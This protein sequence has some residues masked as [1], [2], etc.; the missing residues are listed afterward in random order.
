KSF[1]AF[2]PLKN[3]TY[4][5]LFDLYG[6]TIKATPGTNYFHVGGDEVRFTGD[7]PQLQSY[8]KEHGEFSLYLR[9][10]NNVDNY[11]SKHGRKMI[12]WDD[13]PLKM[14]GLWRLTYHKMPEEK[15]DSLWIR[16]TE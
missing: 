7:N 1:W 9:W 8:K 15:L 13:M 12:F 4:D 16:G 2:N 6:E 10:L 11:I 3:G 14:A 5:L